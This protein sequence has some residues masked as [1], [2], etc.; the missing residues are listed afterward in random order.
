MPSF[1]QDVTDLA[2]FRI[3]PLEQYAY[4]WWQ[5]VLWLMLLS[6]AP[7][8]AGNIRGMGFGEHLAWSVLGS[9]GRVLFY[10][11]FFGWWL[12]RLPEGKAALGE[13][14]L[15]PLLVLLSSS[16]LLVP[17]LAL[18]P[19][20]IA[21]PLIIALKLYQLVLGVRA[22]AISTGIGV[23]HVV[24]GAIVSLPVAFL[25]AMVLTLILMQLGWRP[26]AMLL[27]AEPAQSQGN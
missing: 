25:L 2:R 26:D 24:R 13:R 6:I 19:K 4:D 18:L 11:M 5:P 3:K 27:Q 14:S 9:W 7:M 16:E 10:A 17:V 21:S 1:L 8:F 22:L 12:R 20:L 23:R 15:F